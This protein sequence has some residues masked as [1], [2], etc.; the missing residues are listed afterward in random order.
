MKTEN[1]A[2]AVTVTDLDIKFTTMV[3][4]LL[5]LALAAIPAIIVLALA[6]V[7]LSTFVLMLFGIK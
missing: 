3:N 1:K 4:L 6:G 5:K 7:V 2:Q